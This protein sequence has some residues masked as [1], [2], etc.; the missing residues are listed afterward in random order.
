MSAEVWFTRLTLKRDDAAIAP[1]LQ[2]LAPAN[3]GAAMTTGHRLMWSVIPPETRALHDRA[4]PDRP[5]AA[6][7]LWREAET[8]RKF[9]LLGPRPLEHSPF[10]RIETKPYAPDFRPGHRLVFD[11]R[12]NA[13]VAR[14]GDAHAKGRS[15]RSDVAMD[16]MRAE[17]AAAFA[18][19]VEIPGRAERRLDAAESAAAEWLLRIGARDGFA[20]IALRLEAYRVETLPRRGRDADIGVSDVR[21]ALEVTD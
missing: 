14:K 12:V 20:P 6:A 17:E 7:F 1:L 21:G 15:R 11:L 4:A 16:R 9:Y 3:S 18:A 13:T 10:F 5:E 19:G 8:G 2:E